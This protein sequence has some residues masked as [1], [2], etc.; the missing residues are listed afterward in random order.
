MFIVYIFK[1]WPEA[2]THTCIYIYI[3]YI[4]I[5]IVYD[6]MFEIPAKNYHTYT[7]YKVLANLNLFPQINPYPQASFSVC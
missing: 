2:Y 1:G 7:E 3:I 5:Y 4:Y 6:R